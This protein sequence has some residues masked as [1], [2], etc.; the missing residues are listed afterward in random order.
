[1]ERLIAVLVAR[2][3][4]NVDVAR[5]GVNV[6]EPNPDPFFVRNSMIWVGLRQRLPLLATVEHGRNSHLP[7]W[8]QLDN[9]HLYKTRV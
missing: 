2:F 1:M 4:V 6:L 5:A 3:P 8:R 9:E 7:F